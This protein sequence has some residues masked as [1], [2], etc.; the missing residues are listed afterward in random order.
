MTNMLAESMK[1]TLGLK[2]QQLC[3]NDEYM[4]KAWKQMFFSHPET[5]LPPERTWITDMDPCF[6]RIKE[7]KTKQCRDYPG[8]KLEQIK[9][10]EA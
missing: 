9:K 7:Y 5:D 3:A 8:D 10:V 4:A 6:Q 1:K 2:T